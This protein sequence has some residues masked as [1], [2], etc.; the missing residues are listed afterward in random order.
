MCT[1]KLSQM[2]LRLPPP[3]IV[4]IEV[5]DLCSQDR[6]ERTPKSLFLA[7]FR[8]LTAL[9][10][11]LSDSLPPF[12]FFPPTDITEKPLDLFAA[13]SR[14]LLL[15]NIH[16]RIFSSFLGESIIIGTLISLFHTII[17]V[18]VFSLSLRKKILMM[19]LPRP[20][21]PPILFCCIGSTWPAVS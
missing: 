15:R 5:T 4:R 1:I 16:T 7:P 9:A 11:F 21:Q 2:P 8:Q 18:V 19:C 10:D 20:S 17:P 3:K 13:L 14:A 6:N 12:L